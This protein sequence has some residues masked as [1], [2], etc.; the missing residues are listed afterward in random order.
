MS[1]SAGED[2]LN[3]LIYFSDFF[4]FFF[5]RSV[6]EVHTRIYFTRDFLTEDS[7]RTE[8]PPSKKK[9]KKM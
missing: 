8:L 7:L 2:A 6:F 9:K 1:S 3:S 5:V 4:F